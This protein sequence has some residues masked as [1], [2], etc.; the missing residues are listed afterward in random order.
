MALPFP[1]SANT[2]E[3]NPRSACGKSQNWTAYAAAGTLLA[4]GALLLT[5]RRRAGLVAAATGA[6][7][8]LLDQRDALRDWWNTLPVYLD[9][10][11]HLLG[12]AQSTVDELSA[13]R[14]KLHR[15][16]AR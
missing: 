13:Q 14:E 11:Q 10:A 8:A 5:G 16:L 9:E 1:K 3:S 2:P 4:G 6:A 15:I 12:Q 7:L